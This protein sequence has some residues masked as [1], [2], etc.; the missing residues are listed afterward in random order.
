MATSDGWPSAH[1]LTA[2]QAAIILGM[3]RDTIAKA[4]RAGQ[5]PTVEVGSRMYVPAA[6]LRAW[7]GLPPVV[8]IEA[9]A[10]SR[11]RSRF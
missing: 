2:R 8:P 11:V 6:A 9:P 3:D 10:A 7:L 5:I 4:M 1:L